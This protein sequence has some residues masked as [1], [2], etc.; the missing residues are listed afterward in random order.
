[1]GLGAVARG[2]DIL[3]AGEHEARHDIEDRVAVGA[4]IAAGERWDHDRGKTCARERREICDAE[5]HADRPVVH[6]GRGRDCNEGVAGHDDWNISY[7]PMFEHLRRSWQSLLDGSLPADERREVVAAMKDTLVHARVGIS[8]MRDGLVEVRARLDKERTEL[9]TCTRRKQLAQQ[10][11]DAETVT[12]AAKFE[13]FHQERCTVL[14]RKYG[15]QEAELALAEREV[16][17]M[18]LE[19]KYAA[20]GAKYTGAF[21]APSTAPGGATSGDANSGA[22]AGA[23]G[24]GSPTSASASGAQSQP[25]APKAPSSDRR[26]A[27][28]LD[29]E[30]RLAELKRRM[31]K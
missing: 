17:E 28:E 20:S 22:N 31:G 4:A 24:T 21:G 1:M 3:A 6:S 7:G 16:A 30:L 10:I 8:A 27:A 26:S 13:L 19:L 14:E 23:Q 9:A 18:T 29:A 12:V 2:I 15:A 11:G 5:P 25:G